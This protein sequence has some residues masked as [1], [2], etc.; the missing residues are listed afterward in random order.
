M[1][2]RFTSSGNNTN[3]K[4]KEIFEIKKE[5]NSLREEREILKKALAIFSGQQKR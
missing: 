5:I 2:T 3:P 4:D 1:N